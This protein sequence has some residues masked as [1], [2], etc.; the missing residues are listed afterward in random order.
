MSKLYPLSLF[1]NYCSDWTVEDAIR[2]LL[3]NALDS[4]NEFSFTQGVYSLSISNKDSQLFPRDLLLGVTGKADEEGSVGGYG[5]GFKVALLILLR[6]GIE[7]S[8]FNR[9][10]LWKPVW[11]NS[12]L[13]GTSVL[14]ISETPLGYDSGGLTFTIEGLTEKSIEIIKSRCLYIQDPKEYVLEDDK[15]RVFQEDVSRLFVGGL[16]VSDTT[17]QYSYDFHP[18]QLKLNRD[19]K[20]VSGWD[21]NVA[22]ARLWA[23]KGEAETVASMLLEDSEDVQ[24]LEYSWVAEP[25]EDI[26]E[27]CAELWKKDYKGKPLADN[28]AQ[29]EIMKSKGYTSVV[30]TGRAA[31]N[32]VTKSSQTYKEAE[33]T[34]SHVQSCQ[35][36]ILEKLQLTLDSLDRDNYND[37]LSLID[38]INDRGVNW[39]D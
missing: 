39:N 9:E 7:V 16:Y 33:H 2:E 27:A 11:D 30:T 15:C 8:I 20:S 35:E 12:E 14:A 29:H 28:S 37:I 21:L 26:K 1:P 10:L 24:K 13:F 22:T 17:L 32:Q 5:E 25:R 23:S 4:S 19:R 3:Q 31:F 18:S 34:I 36:L 6:E 38:K